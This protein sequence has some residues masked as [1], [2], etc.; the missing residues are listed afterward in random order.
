MIFQLL[1][2]IVRIFR[3][4]TLFYGSYVCT[5]TYVIMVLKLSNI[6][7]TSIKNKWFLI[8]DQ[9]ITA[10]HEKKHSITLTE[11][12]ILSAVLLYPNF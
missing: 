10:L 1:L 4:K 11:Q 6:V 12:K 3:I 2:W 7:I 5:G 8:V 9:R